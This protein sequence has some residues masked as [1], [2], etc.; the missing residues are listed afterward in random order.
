MGIEPATGCWSTSTYS[1]GSGSVGQPAAMPRDSRTWPA[2]LSSSAAGHST[3]WGLGG[4]AWLSSGERLDVYMT[5]EIADVALTVT[6]GYLDR[7]DTDRARSA[8]DIA[9]LAAPDEEVRRLCRVRLDEVPGDVGEHEDRSRSRE[10]AAPD[11]RAMRRRGPWR[12]TR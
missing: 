2:H 5:V 7:D 6:N 12:T 9:A 8:A 10:A 11:V 4:W 3:S 1:A